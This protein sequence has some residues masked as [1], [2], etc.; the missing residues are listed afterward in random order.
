MHAEAL[1]QLDDRLEH[2]GG[3]PR[4]EAVDEAAV[5]LEDVDRELLRVAERRVAGAEVVDRELHAEVAGASAS[6]RMLRSAS[7]LMTIVSVISRVMRRRVEAE[8]GDDARHVVDDRRLLEL[9]DREV[10]AHRH[11]GARWAG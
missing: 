3:L 8:P 10:D 6:R 5:D 2:R 4:A 1:G 7:V 9:A 11:G